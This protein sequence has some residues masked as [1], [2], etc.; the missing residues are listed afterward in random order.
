MTVTQIRESISRAIEYLSTHPEKSRGSDG[1]VSAVVVEGLKVQVR[2]SRG[3]SLVSD[4]PP[5]V[6]GAGTAPT[7]G[8]L[9]RAA[10]ASCD[11]TVIAMRAA[12]EG[13]ELSDLE[14]VV[15][16]ESDDRGLLGMDESVPP[17]PLGVRIRIRIAAG[18][19]PQE[20]L[21][22]I[23]DW[24]LQHSPVPDAVQRAVPVA[25]EIETS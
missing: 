18:G 14:V 1:S 21:R 4:M 9:M 11:T 15:D 2:G 7:P 8:W 10:I 23:V 24:A 17:G 3:E 16:S 22:E 19:V 6:G 12:Q 20:R 13:V 25:F 5:S